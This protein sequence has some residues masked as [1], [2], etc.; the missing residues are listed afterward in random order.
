MAP[1]RAGRYGRLAVVV[2]N[3]EQIPEICDFVLSNGCVRRHGCGDRFDASL[4]PRLLTMLHVA[5]A[6][7]GKVPSGKGLELGPHAGSMVLRH[8]AEHGGRHRCLRVT[9]A[10]GR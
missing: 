3:A 10:E 9:L 7:L 4:L 1:L 8:L 2:V 6:E 5:S